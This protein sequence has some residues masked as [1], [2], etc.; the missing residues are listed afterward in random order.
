MFTSPPTGNPST[1]TSAAD[2]AVGTDV[3]DTSATLLKNT[4][5]TLPLSA[6]HAGTVAVIGPAAS[7]T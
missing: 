7:S 2:Q 4:S 6:N 1:V 5:R 3:A